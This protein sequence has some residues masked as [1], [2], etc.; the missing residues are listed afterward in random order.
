MSINV[1]LS[2]LGGFCVD[3]LIFSLGLNCACFYSFVSYSFLCCNLVPTVSPHL[4]HQNSH[5]KLFPPLQLSPS[6]FNSFILFLLHL[7]SSVLYL[8]FYVCQFL[9]PILYFSLLCN[10]MFRRKV[11]LGINRQRKK[12]K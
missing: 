1:H 10:S 8:K 5:F 11:L 6:L 7:G 9:F 4:Q 12:K 2:L 3:I